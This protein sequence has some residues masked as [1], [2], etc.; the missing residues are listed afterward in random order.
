VASL[1]ADARFED[2][3]AA[4]ITTLGALLK[5]AGFSHDPAAFRKVTSARALYHWNADANQE[6]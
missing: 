5:H 6:Y 3:T 2:M 1:G 4:D